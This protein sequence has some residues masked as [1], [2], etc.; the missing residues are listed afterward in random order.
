MKTFLSCLTLFAL[1]PLAV[2]PARA[3]LDPSLVS[4]DARWLVYAD[5]DGL[6][7]ST[8]G[9]QLMTALGKIPLPTGDGQIRIDPSKL[10]ATV[11]SVTAFGAN[12]SKDANLVDGTLIIQGTA[13]LR[14][15][16]EAI[17][18]QQNTA[19]PSQILEVKDL[20]YDAYAF[21]QPGATGRSVIIAFPPEP[22]ILISKSREQIQAARALVNGGS[23]S[24]A[25]TPS[26]PLNPLLTHSGSALLFA[27]SL[28]PTDQMFPDGAPQTRILRMATSGSLALGEDGAKT[29]A[30]IELVAS[31]DE[32]ADKLDKILQGMTAMLSLAETND[33]QL[34]DFLQSADVTRTGTTV[35]LSLAYASDRLT[36]MIQGAMAPH[37]ANQA[38]EVTHQPAAEAERTVAHW[39]ASDAT[40]AGQSAND[41][42]VW[43]A[44]PQVTLV[45]GALVSVAVRREG[46]PG[47]A[48]DRV[49]ITPEQGGGAPLV[50]QAEFMTP[51]RRIAGK[52]VVVPNLPAERAHMLQFQFP[53]ADGLYRLRVRYT[54]QANGQ[55]QFSLRVRNPQPPAPAPSQP[56][57][58][59]DDESGS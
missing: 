52:T 55:T 56:S 30:H 5:F 32:M 18:I 40:P 49:E 44:V 42:E 1:S 15:I 6:R 34:N 24:L 58:D 38:T 29:F 27:A 36:Q 14:K 59:N 2:V 53:G 12:F 25:R 17:L 39:T 22:V 26:S 46:T 54:A 51:V 47:L 37:N 11:R 8:V 4:S 10:I 21:T 50:F 41:A 45:N 35:S 57:D 43:H 31:S 7:A 23:A 28:L 16:A 48:F 33:K 20:G 9:R 3:A 13:D 19:N